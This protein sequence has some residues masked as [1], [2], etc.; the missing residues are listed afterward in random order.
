MNYVDWMS[1]WLAGTRLL[2]YIMSIFTMVWRTN[3]DAVCKIT[4]APTTF[5]TLT[6]SSEKDLMFPFLRY[7]LL[8]Q[9]AERLEGESSK[10]T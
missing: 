7:T 1:K 2:L 5:L 3:F 8:N 4:L 9:L 10:F 6:I